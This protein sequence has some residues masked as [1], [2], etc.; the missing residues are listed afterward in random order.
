MEK[1]PDL[2]KAFEQ[3]ENMSRDPKVW[4][5]YW[6][7]AMMD[8]A[9]YKAEMEKLLA[10]TAD[11]QT[12]KVTLEREI[13]VLE[14]RKVTLE[15][16]NTALEKEKSVLEKEKS[17]L[18]KDKAAM[19]DGLLELGRKLLTGGMDIDAVLELM[20]LSAEQLKK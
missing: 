5:K 7:K 17:V 14:T 16:E 2:L 15:K 9:A 13:T 19:E 6:H 10:A 4:V 11:L 20:G 18:E 3:W 12:Q 1:D 8:D